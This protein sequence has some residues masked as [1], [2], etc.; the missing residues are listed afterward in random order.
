VV[1]MAERKRKRPPV[2]NQEARPPTKSLTTTED[3]V[4]PYGDKVSTTG[5]SLPVVTTPLPW[6]RAVRRTKMPLARKGLALALATYANKDGTNAHPGEAR[7]AADCGI[8]EQSV[9]R[10]LAALRDAGLIVRTFRASTTGKRNMADSYDLTVPV[11][12]RNHRSPVT[13]ASEPTTGNST[14]GTT[15]HQLPPTYKRT[16]SKRSPT[17]SVITVRSVTEQAATMNDAAM[18]TDQRRFRLSTESGSSTD[19]PA[20]LADVLAD[21]KLLDRAREPVLN[22]YTAEQRKEN[23]WP[24][25]PPRRRSP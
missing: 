11:Q 17:R 14:T 1:R 5:N 21:L 13:G 9:R 22:A 3:I 15:G 12:G 25:K 16:P 7:L 20:V 2:P 4:P 10:H 24:P 8:N 23:G 19:G 18:R 6:L